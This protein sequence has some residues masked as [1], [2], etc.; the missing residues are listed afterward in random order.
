[1]NKGLKITLII[2]G[3]LMGL[4]LVWM[5]SRYYGC[6]KR[7]GINCKFLDFVSLYHDLFPGQANPST[8]SSSANKGQNLQSERTSC[9]GGYRLNGVGPCIPYINSVT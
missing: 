2:I 9:P 1:M 6:N 3:V 5:A 7:N 8:L 4:L